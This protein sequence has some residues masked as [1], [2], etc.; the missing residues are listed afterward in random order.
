MVDL[1]CARGSWRLFPISLFDSSLML[2]LHVFCLWHLPY[3]AYYSFWDRFLVSSPSFPEA[4]FLV[5][6]GCDITENCCLCPSMP[7]L[8]L[9]LWITFIHCFL[10]AVVFVVSHMCVS[11]RTTDGSGSFL[12]WA[13]G[14]KPSSS[15]LVTGLSTRWVV[16]LSLSSVETGLRHVSCHFPLRQELPQQFFSFALLHLPGI[17]K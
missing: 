11:P 5:L 14:I 8:S 4:C 10:L 2:I 9:Y 12:P 3:S 15:G 6:P 1:S 16:S 7:G 13:A 17:A